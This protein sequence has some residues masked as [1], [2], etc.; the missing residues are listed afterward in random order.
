M[1]TSVLV[2]ARVESG[3][4]LL[5]TL[6]DYRILV[7]SMGW[8]YFAEA[9]SWSLAVSTPEAE[10]MDLSGLY[11]GVDRIMR[12]TNLRSDIGLMD[13]SLQTP[14][15]GLALLLKP[16]AAEF[17]MAGRRFVRAT[18]AGMYVDDLYVYRALYEPISMYSGYSIGEQIMPPID[19]THKMEFFIYP[20]NPSAEAV[21][22]S[23]TDPTLSSGIAGGRA[24]TLLVSSRL[25]R[26][27]GI[28]H[29]AAVT[30]GL[31]GQNGDRHA[32]WRFLHDC[33]TAYVR[34]LIDLM[35]RSGG[36]YLPPEAPEHILDSS[37]PDYGFAGLSD[38]ELLDHE[39]EP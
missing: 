16:L 5:R 38:E 19:T 23:R 39:L 4:K 11:L 15:E 26:V 27:L 21:W 10:E 34:R 20:P 3:W 13:I 36:Q 29:E 12:V 18:I 28:T 6:E 25:R 17:G 31:W 22:Q 9:D 7:Q 30:R 24:P 8:Q 35:S 2:D 14:N 37:M 32:V 33:G 1:D